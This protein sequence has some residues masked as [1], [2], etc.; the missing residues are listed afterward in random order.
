MK[1]TFKIISIILLI[2]LILGG[3][4][5]WFFIR[6]PDT[7][8]GSGINTNSIM[9]GFNPFNRE[10]IKITPNTNTSTSTET[11]SDNNTNV[12]VLNKLRKISETPVGGM[13][14]SST[15][16][17]YIDRGLGHIYELGATSTEIEK[18]SNTT[19]PRVY[20]S[21]WN[22][23][24]NQVVLRYIKANTDEIVNFFGE[25]RP[26]KLSSTTDQNTTKYE[27]KGKFLS[28]NISNVT[29]SPKGDRIFYTEVIDNKTIGYISN[30]DDTKRVK[31]FDSPLIYINIDWPEEN[32]LIMSTKPSGSSYGYIYSINIKNGSQKKIFDG[33]NGFSAKIS[34]DLKRIMYSTTYQDTFKTYVYDI[35]KNK[36]SEV[37]F[38]TLVD[39]CVW[40]NIRKNE[41][42][43][44]VPNSVPKGY[45]P[46]DWYMGKTL[47]TDQIW[48][49]DTES[50]EVHLLSDPLIDSSVKID[51]TKLVLDPK[52]NYLYF[53]NKQDLS[54]WSLEI[55]K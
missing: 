55:N 47:F 25:I 10:P 14:A 41:A 7:K 43:C 27:V 8:N 24:L 45:Y 29:V 4:Y 23:N 50:G 34:R 54:L 53:I 32:T 26:V 13:N 16:I 9:K 2:I 38:N 40:S 48:H 6:T 42:Y 46:D 11:I 36:N 28:K 31:V 15:I 22:K 30:F 51:A 18:I 49:I 3:L 1:K 37:I 20:E 21:Y 39:K 52:E 44:A 19:I 5:F 33:K 35:S 17:R 12:V